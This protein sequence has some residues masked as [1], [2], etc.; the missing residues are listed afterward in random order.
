MAEYKQIAAAGNIAGSNAF[1][2]VFT[3]ADHSDI[4]QLTAWDDEDLAAT[5]AECLV[6]T[7]ANGNKSF[8]AAKSTSDG[9]GAAG[10]TWA[11]GLAQTP[12]AAEANR[13]KG[14]VSYVPLGTT[15]PVAPFPKNRT[16]QFAFGCAADSAPGSVGYQPAVAVK[17]FYTGAPPTVNF[18]YNEGSDGAPSWVAFL[19]SDKGVPLP[20]GI[21]T[22]ILATGP[23]TAGGTSDDGVLDPITKPGSG[24]KFAE[25]YWIRTL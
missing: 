17:C 13:L 22:A 7:A 6:G 23:D 5:T 20:V 9:H 25:E 18:E 1:R 8:L 21:K 19:A 15:A 11:T 24:E 10:S 14:I 12:G 2:C 4:P 16:F 3:V